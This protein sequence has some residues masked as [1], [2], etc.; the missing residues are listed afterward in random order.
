[1][2]LDVGVM[3]NFASFLWHRQN[4]FWGIT[5]ESDLQIGAIQAQSWFGLLWKLLVLI[6]VCNWE[7]GL[8]IDGHPII[9]LCRTDT[10]YALFDAID[11]RFKIFCF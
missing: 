1:M 8:F 10:P 5:I 9:F 6:D 7:F 4:I 3:R 2:N 11:N